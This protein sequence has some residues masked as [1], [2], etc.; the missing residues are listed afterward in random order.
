MN[1]EHALRFALDYDATLTKGPGQVIFK[2]S[3]PGEWVPVTIPE[4]GLP[5]KKGER[6]I[7][8]VPC[9]EDPAILKMPQ[10]GTLM[11]LIFRTGPADII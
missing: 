5:V 7:I 11:G 4:G 10:T 9:G 3:E 1:D 6:F 8:A 2:E